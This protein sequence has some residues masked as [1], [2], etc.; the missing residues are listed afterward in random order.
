MLASTVQFSTNNQTPT[1]T[2]RQPAHS[3]KE[4]TAVRGQTGPEPRPTAHPPGDNTPPTT[5]ARSLRTQQRAYE[6]N[7]PHRHVPP[8]TS[9]GAY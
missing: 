8:P 9:A 2:P 4:A 5:M 3:P 1:P 7:H 6:P